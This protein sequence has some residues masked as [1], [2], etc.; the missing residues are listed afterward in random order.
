MSRISLD[1][2]FV[3]A[4]RTGRTCDY[5]DPPILEVISHPWL[6]AVAKQALGA[7]AVTFFQTALLNAWPDTS[8]EDTGAVDLQA[9][10]SGRDVR[11][12]SD[13]Q[14][15]TADFAA[16]PRRMQVLHLNMA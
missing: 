6:E 14:Y 3:V 11:Y 12:H 15:S 2:V 16:T 4:G 10:E 7:P 9:A 5:Y 13:M 8:A 1:R